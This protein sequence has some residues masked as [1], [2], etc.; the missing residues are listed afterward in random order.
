METPVAHNGQSL[1]HQAEN[2]EADSP[3]RRFLSP[4]MRSKTSA[5]DLSVLQVRSTP[6]T[7]TVPSRIASCDR[8]AAR[9]G[10]AEAEHD[11]LSAIIMR[12]RSGD[13]LSWC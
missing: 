13:A 5:P 9:E 2:S 7:G 8:S 11:A 4:T 12:R 1:A 3:R 6:A 10:Q